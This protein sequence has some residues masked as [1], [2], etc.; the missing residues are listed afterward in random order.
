MIRR[1]I[2]VAAIA[3]FVSVVVPGSPAQARACK[4]DHQCTT[5]YYSDSSHSTQVGSLYEEC[6]G[7]RYSSGRRTGYLTFSEIPCRSSR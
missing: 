2:V 5:Y 1:A 3:V 6:D 4:I 7:S